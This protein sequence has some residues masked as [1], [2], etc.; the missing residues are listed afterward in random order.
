MNEEEKVSKVG[1][2]KEYCVKTRKLNK[3]PVTFYE[4]YENLKEGRK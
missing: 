3:R 2:Y 1:E 4:W